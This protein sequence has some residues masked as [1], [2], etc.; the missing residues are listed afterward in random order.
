MELEN[1]NRIVAN[2]DAVFV[3]V[4]SF[5]VCAQFAAAATRRAAWRATASTNPAP[6]YIRDY[7]G[8]IVRIAA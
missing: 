1:L 2:Y 6:V 5:T 7:F 4:S 8:E 3:N